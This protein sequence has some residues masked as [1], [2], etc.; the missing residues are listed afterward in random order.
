MSLSLF[1]AFTAPIGEACHKP[2]PTNKFRRMTDPQDSNHWDLLASELGA[3]PPPEEEKKPQVEPDHPTQEPEAATEGPAPDQEPPPPEL[4][5]PELPPKPR[6]APTDWSQLAEELGIERREEA[7]RPVTP[8]A[9]ALCPPELAEVSAEAPETSPEAAS[10]VG[11]PTES[12]PESAETDVESADVFPG[13]T[14]PDAESAE[15]T[16]GPTERD[17]A[18][19]LADTALTDTALESPDVRDEPAQLAPEQDERKTGRRRRRR[20]RRPAKGT[21]ESPAEAAARETG[22]GSGEPLAGEPEGIPASGVEPEHSVRSDAS[23][24]EA[25]ESE[26]RSER[27]RRSPSRKRTAAGKDDEPGTPE[28]DRERAVV[29]DETASPQEGGDQ[30]AELEPEDAKGQ[31]RVRPK[32]AKASHRGIPTW[33]EAV[34]IVISANMGSRAKS[35]TGGSSS[36]SRGGRRPAGRDRSGEKAN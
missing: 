14:V 28:S 9:E 29:G 19:T 1:S 33:E 17:F 6:R 34:G 7:A 4:P 8:E 13:S 2:R 24:V 22:L 21:A 20:G 12:A 26:G 16:I 18:F 15:P 3:P 10:P 11:A 36:R 32:E 5:P 35:S 27:R 31:R 25:E 30:S 23:A